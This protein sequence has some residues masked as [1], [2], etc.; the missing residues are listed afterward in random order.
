MT[1][2]MAAPVLRDELRQGRQ[3]VLG[4]LLLSTRDLEPDAIE[5]ILGYQ[6]AHGLRFGEAAVALGL[7]AP[8]DVE[9]ALAR[10]FR[11]PVAPASDPAAEH[12]SAELVT[13]RAPYSPQAEVFRSLRAQWRMR[14]REHNAAGAALAVLSPQ[15]GDG[16]SYVAANLAVA[17]SQGGGRTLLI[18]ADLRRPRQHVLFGLPQ[19][20]APRAAPGSDD[21]QAQPQGG[22]AHMLSGRDASLAVDP[23]PGLP[24]LFVLAAGAVPPNPLELLE[25]AAFGQLLADVRTK[26]DHVIVDSAPWSLGMD[27]PVTAAAC[28]AALLVLRPGLSTLGSAQDLAAAVAASGTPVLGAVFNRLA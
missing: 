13:A 11:Y 23:V 18:D 4:D 19:P 24:S 22:L 7:A 14:L 12:L 2:P 9:A 28:G 25:S 21:L 1:A 15:P 5:R 17:C 8:S 26:F 20:S 27:G 16:R 3:A 6:R 10:Q